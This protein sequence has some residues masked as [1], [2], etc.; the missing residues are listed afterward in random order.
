MPCDW[1]FDA[2]SDLCELRGLRR[3]AQDEVNICTTDGSFA[4]D[5]SKCTGNAGP[6]SQG[7]VKAAPYLESFDQEVAV[8]AWTTGGDPT[9]SMERDLDGGMLCMEDANYNWLDFDNC[10]AA[11]SGPGDRT[12]GMPDVPI[13][14]DDVSVF[15][16]CWSCQ[17]V[18]WYKKQYCHCC[19][20]DIVDEK[21]GENGEECC[22][23]I[24]MACGVNGHDRRD[25]TPRGIEICD[26][27][28]D[29]DRSHACDLLV[30]GTT[31]KPTY[32]KTAYSRSVPVNQLDGV[33]LPYVHE[34][35][36]YENWLNWDPSLCYME[37]TSQDCAALDGCVWSEIGGH[38]GCV[39]TSK[40]SPKQQITV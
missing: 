1:W 37:D 40:Q 6:V 36:D 10:T 28:T 15:N 26:D 3:R 16:A 7:S 24:D 4:G 13:H 39:K 22:D 25:A 8:G 12:P 29:G 21:T 2:T 23:G 17:W 35:A 33:H 27:I 14:P 32:E 31:H 5:R 34:R 20:P 11:I 38:A 30:E 19:D 18:M 9:W